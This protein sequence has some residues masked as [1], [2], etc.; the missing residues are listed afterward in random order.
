ME[1]Y[2]FLQILIGAVV[3]IL[4]VYSIIGMTV[5]LPGTTSLATRERTAPQRQLFSG[6]GFAFFGA[7]I[8]SF[9]FDDKRSANS[10]FGWVG[11]VLGV[12]ALIFFL[13]AL[14]SRKSA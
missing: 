2:E 9:A 6:V 1:S 4:G 5:E 8:I 13:M 7:M 11:V 12:L 14:F 3:M 10:V